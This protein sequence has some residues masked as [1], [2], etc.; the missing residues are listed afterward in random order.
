VAVVKMLALTL[1]GP[2]EETEVV[3]R[4]MVL[5]G[6]FQPIP[7]DLLVSDRKMRARVG[8]PTDNPYDTLLT[9]VAS[10]WHA[11]GETLPEPSPILSDRSFTLEKARCMVEAAVRK[12]DLWERRKRELVESVEELE[13]AKVLLDTLHAVSHSLEDLT[14]MRHMAVFFGR[15]S[16]ENGKRLLETSEDVPF[17]PI[18]LRV[19]GGDMWVLCFAIPGYRDGAVKLL[20][21]VNFKVFSLAQMIERL[22]SAEGNRVDRLIANR[23]RA[24]GGLEKAARNFLFDHRQELVALFNQIYTMQR[25]Y[26]LCKGRGEIGDMYLLSGWI[27]EDIREEALSVIAAEAPKTA[28]FVEET[29]HSLASGFRV[30]T[31]LRN[32]PFVRSFQEIVAIY[33]LPSYG[34][35]DPSFLVALSFCAM[36]GFMFGDVGHGLLLAL[37]GHFLMKRRAVTKAIGA[38]IKTAGASSVLFGFLYGSVFGM[39][40]ILPPLWFSPMEHMDRLLKLSLGAGVGFVTLGMLLNM[41]ARYR[42]GDFGRLL[43]DG[44]GLAGLV[45]YWSA[46]LMAFSAFSGIPLPFPKWVGGTLLLILLLVIFL[47]DVL[48]RTLLKRRSTEVEES[49]VVHVFEVLHGLLSFLSNTASFVRLAAFALNHVGLSLAV[50]M[51]AD[52]VHNVPG[53]PILK[54]LL[55]FLGNLLIVGLEGL[56]V[57]IQTLRLEYYE[58]FSKF[59]RGGGSPFR[60]VG[61]TGRD[62]SRSKTR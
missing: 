61:W 24:A 34:E 30:P 47:R 35:M 5:R 4:Q 54:V 46:A 43:F 33:S 48:A 39:E 26:D 52:M 15:I 32:L 11:A 10:V 44:Q 41:V 6:G 55:L 38:V 29:A 50:F 58:F 8:T 62:L 36:F 1:A 59:Y 14:T 7:L 3:A 22:R 9:K 2:K 42:E 45:F 21:S 51:L 19:Q 37:G 16:E 28:V 57:F 53:G 40:G 56:I 12:L 18:P 49:P 17:L 31:L 20:E 27:P 60:P 13:A 23:R 25:V